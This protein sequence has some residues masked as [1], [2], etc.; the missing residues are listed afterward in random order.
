MCL[1]N[2]VCYQYLLSVCLVAYYFNYFLHQ[3]TFRLVLLSCKMAVFPAFTIKLSETGDWGCDRRG[4]F[5]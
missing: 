2:T 1:A 4:C 3:L 5:F